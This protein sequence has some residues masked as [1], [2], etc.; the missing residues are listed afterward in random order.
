MERRRRP[1]RFL[2]T[3]HLV[4]PARHDGPLK[5]R[6]TDERTNVAACTHA[7][8]TS[9]R[10][11]AAQC[12]ALWLHSPLFSPHLACPRPPTGAVPPPLLFPQWRSRGANQTSA[13]CRAP[14][15]N[16]ERERERERGESSRGAFPRTLILIIFFCS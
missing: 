1:R 5:S 11:L 14:F 2:A 12:R 7:P 8:T 9:S 16:G 15:K 13:D 10:Y 6:R 3:S 4:D